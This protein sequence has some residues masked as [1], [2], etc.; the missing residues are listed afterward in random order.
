MGKR[1]AAK[2]FGNRDFRE[3]A[4]KGTF[5]NPDLVTDEVM[6]NLQL[7]VQSKGYLAGTTTMMGQYEPATESVL[8]ADIDVPVVIIWGEQD[9]AKP[10][11]ELGKLQDGFHDPIMVVVPEVGHYVHEEAPEI[12]V[13]AL[14]DGDSKIKMVIKRS[15]ESPK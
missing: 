1:L 15:F 2:Q 6:D 9:H 10:A 11:E 3:T 7:A 12:V 14:I 5:V 8:M 4:L 13:N